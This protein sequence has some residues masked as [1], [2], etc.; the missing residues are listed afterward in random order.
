MAAMICVWSSPCSGVTSVMVRPISQRGRCRREGRPAPLTQPTMWTMVVPARA[1]PAR[2]YTRSAP[3]SPGV[4]KH[5]CAPAAT[6]A[7]ADA[8]RQR[9]CDAAA[10]EALAHA[11][12]A[13]LADAVGDRAVERGAGR[14]A[15]GARQVPAPAVGG[16]L[17]VGGR[18]VAER[19][20]R[21]GQ[22]RAH[23]AA[24][25]EDARDDHAVGRR[26]LAQLL[27]RQGHHRV[28]ALQRE[29]VGRERLLEA[30]RAL[31]DELQA[32]LQALGGEG[33]P[34]RVDPLP[35]GRAG[36]RHRV[37]RVRMIG[38]AVAVEREGPG[39]DRIAL[40]RVDR[41]DRGLDALGDVHPRSI[42]SKL[43]A[44]SSPIRAWPIVCVGCRRRSVGL[45]GL[46]I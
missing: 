30:R 24:L 31:G 2:A 8:P 12:A 3:S 34:Q 6:A 23:V 21:R 14:L 19:L 11:D 29:A 20:G 41:A 9:G 38:G 1:K 32:R 15:V 17:R 27:G 44:P 42:S 43:T 28:A 18:A 5:S 22:Q 16:D 37:V 13:E 26:H 36:V 33:G 46:K 7:A 10:A 35:P 40:G 39:D 45:P 4:R 25:G